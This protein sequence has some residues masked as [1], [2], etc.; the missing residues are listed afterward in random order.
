[1]PLVRPDPTPAVESSSHSTTSNPILRKIEEYVLDSRDDEDSVD[2]LVK[3]EERVED[4]STS[5]G[6]DSLVGGVVIGFSG[7]YTG[8]PMA[9]VGADEDRPP[10]TV[11]FVEPKTRQ[12]DIIRAH[13]KD[14]VDSQWFEY[15]LPNPHFRASQPLS[16]YMSMYTRAFTAGMALPVHPFVKALCELH[17]ISP[18]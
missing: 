10:F 9:S 13:K 16:G 12:R 6:S 3:D 8:I 14:H 5:S 4:P 11:G 18:T 1:M 15:L 7:R 2:R 17:G